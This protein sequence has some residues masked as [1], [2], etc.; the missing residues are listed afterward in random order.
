[1]GDLVHSF[2]YD[3]ELRRF[4]MYDNTNRRPLAIAYQI[5]LFDYLFS[6]HYDVYG[7]IDKGLAID[8]RSVN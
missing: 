1:M 8:K 6:H 5:D 3:P 4:S 7:L 2:R